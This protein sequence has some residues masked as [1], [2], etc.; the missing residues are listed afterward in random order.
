M[1]ESMIQFANEDLFSK[2]IQLYEEKSSF[3]KL[4]EILPKEDSLHKSLLLLAKLRD[5]KKQEA[6]SY[7]QH[8]EKF[9]YEI[10]TGL[11]STSNS[12]SLSLWS[13]FYLLKQ[14]KLL[15]EHDLFKRFKQCCNESFST[16]KGTDLEI[17]K[18]VLK[19]KREGFFVEVGGH[20]GI[21][22]SYTL[23][24]EEKLDWNGISIEASPK[25]FEKMKRV[26]NCIC[27]QTALGEF[28]SK[29]NFYNFTDLNQMNGLKKHY[30]DDKAYQS[31]LKKHSPEVINV[32]VIPFNTLANKHNINHIDFFV[33]D[34]EGA[35]FEV[36]KGINFN[37]TSV[38]YFLIE[39]PSK[40]LHKYLKNKNYRVIGKTKSD[41]MFA[42]KDSPFLKL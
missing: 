6:E 31:F 21:S 18:N 35:E 22:G 25:E 7:T 38:S 4:E 2:A 13:Y 28:P 3:S 5:G 19:K 41:V 42:H 17:I 30:R 15:N 32:D 40:E 33:I 11:M 8:C 26:R 10:M 16:N 14:L 1:E 23:L 24:L 29:E 36:V 9:F 27:E 39:D 20:N 34:V 37:N 12:K